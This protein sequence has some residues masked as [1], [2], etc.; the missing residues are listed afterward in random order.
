MKSLK[1]GYFYH[2]YN[3][4]AGRN[5]LF[6]SKDDYRF[7]LNKYEYY[8]SPALQTF[9]WCLMKNHFH[10]L[11]R[12]LTVEEQVNFYLSNKKKFESGHYHGTKNPKKKP[13]SASKQISHFMN[14]Y[15][16]YI[17]RKKNRSGTLIEGPFK[18]IQVLDESNF[19]NLICYIHRNPIHHG[20]TK[21]YSDYPHSSYYDFLKKRNRLIELDQVIEKFGGIKNFKNA[22]E[23]FRLQVLSSDELLLE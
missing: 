1:E 11:V 12:P 13:F 15:T 18:R 5:K 23:E 10:F 19:L 21:S 7:F 3:R 17:N 6:F 14:S 4:G 8:L 20:F 2:I 22:H 16:R 9:A